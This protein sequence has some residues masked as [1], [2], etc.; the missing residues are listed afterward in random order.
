MCTPLSN[1]EWSILRALSRQM[2]YCS[3]Y[4]AIEILYIAISLYR[5]KFRN[6]QSKTIKNINFTLRETNVVLLLLCI[7]NCIYVYGTRV[8]ENLQVRYYMRWHLN[9]Q[10][11]TPSPLLI[12]AF[13]SYFQNNSSPF[14][15]NL[16]LSFSF[17]A[18]FRQL[19]SG[20]TN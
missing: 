17:D 5:F 11:R 4:T 18:Y 6:W 15:A 16:W 3:S 9:M 19:L 7:L 12:D 8:R 20:I 1:L 10:Q 2:K 13:V 14:A